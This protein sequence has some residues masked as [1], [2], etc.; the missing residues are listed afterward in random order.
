MDFDVINKPSGVTKL[1]E[2]FAALGLGSVTSRIILGFI[3]GSGM[4]LLMR[5]SFAF[6]AEGSRPLK[7]IDSSDPRGTYLPWYAIG[8][9]FAMLLGI[10][11]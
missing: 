2:A 11:W 6:D 8:V 10:F 4:S 9:V 7:F 1:G 5:P 3:L